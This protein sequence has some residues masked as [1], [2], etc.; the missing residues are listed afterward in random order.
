MVY[1]S[2]SNPAEYC[3]GNWGFP[4]I[5]KLL[6]NPSTFPNIFGTRSSKSRTP[7]RV[8]HFSKILFDKAWSGYFN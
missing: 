2:E 7:V 4:E 1:Y 3:K 6:E 5:P 8:V